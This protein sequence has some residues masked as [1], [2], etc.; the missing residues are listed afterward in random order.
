M[1]PNSIERLISA[2]ESR[3]YP[4][5]LA[6]RHVWQSGLDE[7]IAEL[8]ARVP[9]DDPRNKEAS[10]AV[11]AMAAALYLWN[12]SLESAHR[13]VQLFEY[14]PTFDLLH[15]IVH[16]REGD[17]ANSRYWLRNAGHHPAYYG[18]QARAS[19]LL[20][21][22]DWTEVDAEAG[23]ALNAMAEQGEWNPYLFLEA[24]AIRQSRDGGEEAKEVLEQLQLLEL[25]SIVRYLEGLLRQEGREGDEA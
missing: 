8:A 21:G 13:I 22:K 3:P 12:D 11:Q 23:S 6:P 19:R 4:P 16:R 5:P 25:R 7:E 2:L 10:Q 1:N 9:G 14:I 15:G 24:V 17:Y 20:E 18:L